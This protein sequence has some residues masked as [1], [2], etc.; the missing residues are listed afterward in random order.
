MNE[1]NPG[2]QP[3]STSDAI[4]A[5]TLFLSGCQPVDPSQPCTNLYDAEILKAFGYHGEK[6]GEAAN[7]AWKDR[8]KGHVQYHVVLTERS[9]YLIKAH[10]DQMELIE[11]GEGRAFDMLA[12]I[13]DLFKKGAFAED[14]AIMR[15]ACVALKTRGEFVNVWKQMVPLLRIPVEGRAKRFDT[16]ARVEGKVIDVKGVHRPG[17]K[18][19]SLNMTKEHKKEMKL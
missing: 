19:I 18:V 10:R 7:Q 9:Q 8:K 6:L 16:T 2:A 3:Y 14:E 5:I 15:L 4:L 12:S 17:F 11:K 13:L 1:I